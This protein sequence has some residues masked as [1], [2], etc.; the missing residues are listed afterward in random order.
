[1]SFLLNSVDL[2]TYGIRAGRAN[3]SNICLAGCFDLPARIGVTS[4]DW[5]EEDGTEPFVTADEIMFAG[6]DVSFYGTIFGTNTEI[7]TYLAALKVSIDGL[8]AAGGLVSFETP[9]CDMGIYVKNVVVER[10]HGAAS[11]TINFRETIVVLT[12]GTLPST[13]ANNNQID[14]IPL[15]SFGLYLSGSKDLYDIAEL[16]DQ[17]FTRYGE[18]G[19]PVPAP[20]RKS[21]T[22]SLNGFVCGTSL[23]DFQDKIKALYLIFSSAGTRTIKLNNEVSVVCFATEGFRVSNVFIYNQGVIANFDMKLT[24]VSVTYL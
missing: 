14:G 2:L 6:R 4:H 19:A 16:K 22:L 23:S 20:K 8:V 9:Y 21:K 13:G 12:G 7:N 24:I 10:F 3:G 18:E 17:H 5:D 15:S 11:I 1:M